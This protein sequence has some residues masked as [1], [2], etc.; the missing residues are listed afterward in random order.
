VHCTFIMA[1]CDM[2][3]VHFIAGRS[4]CRGYYMIANPMVVLWGVEGVL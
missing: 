3:V 4:L 2:T 1:M